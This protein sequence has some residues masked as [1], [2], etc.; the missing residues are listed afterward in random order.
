MLFGGPQKWSRNL[1]WISTVRIIHEENDANMPNCAKVR[2]A[3]RS[4]PRW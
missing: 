4:R 1:N 3:F 2:R